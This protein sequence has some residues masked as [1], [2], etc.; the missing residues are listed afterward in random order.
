MERRRLSIAI[1]TYN[2]TNVLYESFAGVYDDPRVESIVIVDDAS[3][4]KV[5]DELVEKL[6]PLDKVQLY[7]NLSNADCYRNKYNAV[8]FC[9]TEFCILL[10]SDNRIDKNYLDRVFECEW[11]PDTILTPSFAAPH[12]DF[13]MFEGLTITKEN[14]AAHMDKPMFETMLNAANYFVHC[15]SYCKAFDPGVDPVTSDSIFI[16]HQWLMNAGKIFVVPKLN[17]FHRVWPESHYR[18]QNH[19]TPAGFHQSI[20]QKLKQAV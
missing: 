13:T 4:A 5:F 12:F 18:T 10:D 19:R 20:I 3:E 15:E 2:R 17:Y 1:P 8:A 14:V 16:A 6:E 11:R 7:R 9:Q